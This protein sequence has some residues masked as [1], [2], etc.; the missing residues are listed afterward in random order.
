MEKG[1]LKN[2]LCCKGLKIKPIR[3]YDFSPG[4]CK[5]VLGTPYRIQE[6]NKASY[7][8]YLHYEL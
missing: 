5:G 8:Y 1:T 6:R 4:P 2:Q 3:A 7:L